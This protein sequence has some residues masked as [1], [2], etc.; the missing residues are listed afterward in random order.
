MSSVLDLKTFYQKMVM[1]KVPEAHD[2]GHFNIVRLEDMD[3]RGTRKRPQYSRRN[4]YKVSLVSGQSLIHYAGETYPIDKHALVFTN[5]MIPYQWETISKRQ[6]GY[7]CVFMPE[8]Y[9][10]AKYI[11]DYPVFRY[12]ANGVVPLNDTEASRYRMLFGNMYRD[13]SSDYAFKYDYLRTQLLGVVHEA[14][15][16]QPAT[17]KAY[18]G[19]TAQERIALL[20]AD[21]LERQFPI[22]STGQRLRLQTPA[23]FAQHLHLHVNHLNKALKAI[24]GKTTSQLI[25]DRIIQEAK[26]MLSD[27]VL[28]VGDIAWAL[29]FDEPNHFS[30]FF[31]SRTGM[32]PNQFRK[33]E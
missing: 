31:K 25:A 13:L 16:M 29:G 33:S 6:T 28:P 11:Y 5:P 22:D 7:I 20:F 26:L 32:T 18:H 21:L 2:I 23:D 10:N 14:Q 9:G 30:A 1:Q 3:F 8:F 24:T 12:P 4:Y 19:T 17:G 15:K 27:S